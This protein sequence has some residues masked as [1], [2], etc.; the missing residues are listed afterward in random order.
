MKKWVIL[1]I[2]LLIV[3]GMTG[4]MSEEEKLARDQ[5]IQEE[6]IAEQKRKDEEKLKEDQRK[7]FASL[8]SQLSKFDNDFDDVDYEILYAFSLFDAKSISTN[9]YY[10][11]LD[12][13]N[14]EIK[15]LKEK[16]EKVELSSKFSA[17]QKERIEQSI[18]M[19]IE[20]L[21]MYLESIKL[22]RDLGK[23]KTNSLLLK[24]DSKH[25]ESI[26]KLIE[27]W[28]TL[29]VIGKELKAISD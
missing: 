16:F 25:T 9:R 21:E 8:F 22:F 27:S 11:K 13:Y 24:A 17:N 19:Y 23:K 18:S 3:F 28:D 2:V 10:E 26:D 15:L 7:E 4:C 20:G 1:S 29:V 12:F 5:K 6:R 14:I